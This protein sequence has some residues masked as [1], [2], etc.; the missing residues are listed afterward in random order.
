VHRAGT[1][2]VLYRESIRFDVDGTIA[3]RA[4]PCAH[5]DH[6]AHPANALEEEREACRLAGMDGHF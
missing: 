4:A 5:A 3:C 6:R 1:H 2:S